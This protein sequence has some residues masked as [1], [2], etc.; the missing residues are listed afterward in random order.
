MPGPKIYKKLAWLNGLPPDEAEYVFRQCSGSD[1]WSR[2][3]AAARPF[4]ML[5][6]LFARS[7]GIWASMTVEQRSETCGTA[8]TPDEKLR[9]IQHEL[10]KL[11]ER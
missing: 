8:A 11:L 10:E 4:P 3:M 9:L 5:E 2:L 7:S 6:H 1:E